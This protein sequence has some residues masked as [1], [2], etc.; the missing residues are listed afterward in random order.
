[1][2][3]LEAVLSDADRFGARLP[4]APDDLRRACAPV[5]AGRSGPKRPHLVHFDLWDGNVLA[6]GSTLCGLI[7]AERA[8]FG[9]P[10][11]D[12][13]SLTLFSSLDDHDELLAGYRQA[14]GPFRPEDESGRQRVAC[15]RA[16]LY[17]I[18]VTESVPRAYPAEL[19]E[20]SRRALVSALEE[21]D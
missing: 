17:L 2:A 4:C 8:F 10:Y 9:D 3:M 12:F 1:E 6:E 11:A 5:L 16:Y 7:D 19:V 18:M 13:A 20:R 14:G 15:Y 21:L